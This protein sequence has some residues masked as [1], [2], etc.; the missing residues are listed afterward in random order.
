MLLART[1]G[2]AVK[3]RTAV[4]LARQAGAANAASHPVGAG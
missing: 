4:T 1:G 2:L 3:A